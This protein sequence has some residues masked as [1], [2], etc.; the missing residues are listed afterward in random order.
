MYKQTKEKC[1][2]VPLR[3]ATIPAATLS[4]VGISHVIVKVYYVTETFNITV[5]VIVNYTE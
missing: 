2:G 4:N 1:N 3:H 5:A